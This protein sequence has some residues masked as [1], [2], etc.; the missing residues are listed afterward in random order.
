[1]PVQLS[2]SHNHLQEET[3]E[4]SEHLSDR[5][6]PHTTL[7]SAEH[8]QNAYE[9]KSNVQAFVGVE[10]AFPKYFLS[11]KSACIWEQNVIKD[12]RGVRNDHFE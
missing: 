12:V 7:V 5:M 9:G 11:S 10:V 6:H 3:Q 8:R 4:H 1:M 2:N